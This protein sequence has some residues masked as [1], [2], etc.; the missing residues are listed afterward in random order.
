MVTN[1]ALLRISSLIFSANRALDVGFAIVLATLGVSSIPYGLGN[2]HV[3]KNLIDVACQPDSDIDF[4]SHLRFSITSSTSTTRPPPHTA[5]C[6]CSHVQA[7][8]RAH[9]VDGGCVELAPCLCDTGVILSLMTD[10]PVDS[11]PDSEP[12]STTASSSLTISSS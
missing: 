4:Q 10:N 8:R 7:I 12:T 11:K 2:Y 9:L 3:T 5:W 1:L 6:P